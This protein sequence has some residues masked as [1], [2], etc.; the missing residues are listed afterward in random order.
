MAVRAAGLSPLEAVLAG[1]GGAGNAT[2]FGWPE[3]YP[4]V[5]ERV[6][7]ARAEAERLT[8]ELV[9]PAYAGLTA[10]AAAELDDLLRSAAEQ[11]NRHAA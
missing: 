10:A 9:A 7:S 8:S 1:A 6:R 2:F 4:E 3:P 11:V 5:S